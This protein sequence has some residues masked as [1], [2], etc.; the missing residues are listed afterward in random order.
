[1]QIKLPLNI[2]LGIITEVLYTLSIML[3]A[4]LI[5]ILLVPAF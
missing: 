2:T 1:M 5:C 3:A 4:F